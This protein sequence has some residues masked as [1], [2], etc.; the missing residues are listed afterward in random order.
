MLLK[1][2]K[3][4]PTLTFFFLLDNCTVA[5]WPYRIHHS[6]HYLQ[7]RGNLEWMM[8]YLH[9]ELLIFT[10]LGHLRD[11]KSCHQDKQSHFTRLLL[12]P[13]PW[14][15]HE[16]SH[17]WQWVQEPT[18]VLC[19]EKPH[20]AFILAFSMTEGHINISDSQP[21]WL[22]RISVKEYKRLFQNASKN[23][24]E[25]H[26]RETLPPTRLYCVLSLFLGVLT[27]S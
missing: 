19:P 14:F 1:R 8:I 15:R 7:R 10:S 18:G 24:S 9:G 23:R 20:K 13:D 16:R 26:Q 21:L 25:D 11:R 6:Q 17:S 4:R 2:E 27:I 22:R 12:F 5:Q 3:K